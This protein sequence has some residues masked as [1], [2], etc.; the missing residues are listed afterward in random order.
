[1]VRGAGDGFV[2]AL[3]NRLLR[4]YWDFPSTKGTKPLRM[5]HDDT[6]AGLERF[7]PDLLRMDAFDVDQL[8]ATIATELDGGRKTADDIY[9][10]YGLGKEKNYD[11]IYQYA[12]AVENALN[13]GGAT[14]GGVFGGSNPRIQTPRV[15]GRGE[16][17]GANG[18]NGLRR[19]LLLGA[20]QSAL[21]SF[22]ES[23]F[24]GTA[25]NVSAP[26]TGLQVLLKQ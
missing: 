14:F 18:S 3:A 26:N 8:C 19:V 21:R 7:L 5:T 16:K 13:D 23:R 12:L 11:P 1:M 22:I 20:A 17:R 15:R 24:I 9:A 10:A 2:R 25:Q 6:R 4:R